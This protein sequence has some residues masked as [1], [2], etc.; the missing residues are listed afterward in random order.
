MKSSQ[1]L[2]DGLV[3]PYQPLVLF[4]GVCNLCNHTVQILL[5]SGNDTLKFAS[6]QSPVGRAILE[7][8]NLHLEGVDSVVLVYQ[9]NIHVYSTA[10]MK[11]A[12]I[13]G[14]WW[15]LLKILYIFPLVIRDVIYRWVARNRYRIF[16]KKDSCM[17]PTPELRS[18]FI[19]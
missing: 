17:I 18:R 2:P 13:V 1:Q 3:I 6:L 4:D 14:G 19:E 12:E 9:G 15:K 8:T 7:S 10:I 11:I 5:K 16:G